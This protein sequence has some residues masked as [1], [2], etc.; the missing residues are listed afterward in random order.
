MFVEIINRH[1]RKAIDNFIF[2]NKKSEILY[3]FD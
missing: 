3:D 2:E 1:I